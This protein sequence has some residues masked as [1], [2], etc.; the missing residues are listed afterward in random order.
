MNRSI[1]IKGS[2]IMGIFLVIIGAAIGCSM[3]KKDV[4]V[5]QI[6]NGDDVYFTS[7]DY[8]ITNQELWE[9]LR[10]F[11]GLD[12]LLDYVNEIILADYIAA[13]TQEEIDDEIQLVLYQTDNEERIAIIQAD[14]ELNQEYLDNFNQ[15]LVI[16]GFDPENPDDL[17]SFV[18]LSIAK[19]KL[20][21]QFIL[22]A[23]PLS[24]YEIDSDDIKNFYESSTKNDA[25]VLEVRFNSASE[26]EAVFD[27]FDI[28]PNY[29]LGFGSYF[30]ETDITEVSTDLFDETNTTQL[31]DDEV[32]DMYIDFYNYLNPY[33]EE[34]RTEPYVTIE[35]FCGEYSD[36]STYNYEDMTKDK[37]QGDPNID[38][39][40]Y[41]FNILD[42]TNEFVIP[43]SY[44]PVTMGDFS[45]LSYKISEE[46]IK[47]YEDVT[48]HEINE[49]REELFELIINEEVINIALSEI[50]EDRGF[51]IF[52]PNL[53]LLYEFEHGVS[54]DNLGS[55]TLVA[56]FDGIDITADDLF[57]YMELRLGAF[58]TI[59]I[60]K[61][62][63]LINSDAY[64]DVYGEE[65]DYFDNN[66]DE[67]K[68]H[69][70]ELRG[71]K[72]NFSNSIYATYGFSPELY[73]WEEF[74]FLAFS[75]DS[76]SAVI[77]QLFIV[78]TLQPTVIYETLSYDSV[79]AYLTEQV[80]NYFSLN[81][82]H[83]LMFLD[84]DG[85][86]LPDDFDELITNMN[87]EELAEYNLLKN[88]FENLI[89]DK[90]EEELTFAQIVDE[91]RDGLINDVDNEYAI[92][93]QYGFRIIT[94]VLSTEG[95]LNYI[96]S[97]NLDESFKTSL[98]RIYDTFVRPDFLETDEYYDDRLTVSDFGIHLIK[99]TPGTDFIQPTA[100]F[101]DDEAFSEGSANDSMVPNESQVELY[102]EIK[103]AEF[104]GAYTGLLLPTSVYDAL[105]IYYYSVFNAYFS[106][107]GF[108]VV[109][110]EYILGNS[111]YYYMGDNSDK[112]DY[113]GDLLEAFYQINFPEGFIPAE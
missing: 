32:F 35:E 55:D 109:I 110:T 108:T 44:Y 43:Y 57:T 49:L 13:I 3:I 97:Q 37:I 72:T 58:Y 83:I 81:V 4:L 2:I 50:Y 21:A 52:D 51:E 22:D 95:S 94:E 85:D 53:N 45:I 10:N 39:A 9:S 16:L 8:D 36:I 23:A 63:A 112:L 42:L 69:R 47:D 31:T 62:R 34:I 27:Y 73:T 54:F 1:L 65:R 80:E 46:P 90:L 102:N 99:A 74:L 66:S 71:M 100:Y 70:D 101:E 88:D 91:F 28:V 14:E 68:E 33:K 107:T 56:K 24:T 30:G 76:E 113:I 40:G 78:G 15:N 59:E 92:F 7:S 86:F 26:A 93:K 5:P 89:K 111:P 87:V 41:L 48:A 25:C 67:M 77:E 105:E 64:D 20:A 104:K 18:E 29:S 6:S 96:N 19:Q 75:A 98:K 17:R 61:I 38:Y 60:S 106:Q 12:Y 79:G 82:E 11:S 84:F 103:Y